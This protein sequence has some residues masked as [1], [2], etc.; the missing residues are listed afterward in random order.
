MATD[1]LMLIKAAKIPAGLFL[2]VLLGCYFFLSL[3]F[4]G[5][6]FGDRIVSPRE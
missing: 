5:K 1:T 2:A 3:F 6:T 4:L